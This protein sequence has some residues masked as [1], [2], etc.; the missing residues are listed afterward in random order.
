MIGESR[1]TK[2][3]ARNRENTERRLSGG[4]AT[5]NDRQAARRIREWQRDGVSTTAHQDSFA[6][7]I[8]SI[9]GERF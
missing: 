9:T 1:H 6:E 7:R 4:Y 3:A 8:E 5:N 2:S